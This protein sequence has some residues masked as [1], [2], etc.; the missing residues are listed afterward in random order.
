M[1]GQLARRRKDAA[2]A[3]ESA[4]QRELGFFALTASGVGIIIGAGIYVLIGAA[5]EKAGAPVWSAFLLAATLSALSGLGYCEL[6]TMFPR[7]AAE[8]EYSRHALPPWI[9]FLTGWLMISGLTVASAAVSLGFAEYLAHFFEFIPVKLGAVMLLAVVSAIALGGIRNSARLTIVMSLI[10]VGGLLFVIAV[11]A[12]HVGEVDVFSGGSTAGIAGAAA[13][14]F[15]AFIGFDEVTTLAEE[16]RNPGRNVP[17]ALIV[18]LVISTI[19]YMAVAVV[20]VSVLGPVALGQSSTPLADVVGQATGR[21]LDDVI[22]VIALIST[23]NTTLLATTAGSRVLY[24]MASVK[25]MPG[26]FGRVTRRHAPARAIMVCALISMAFA[27]AGDLTL[28]ASVTDFSVYMVFLSV[29]ATVII[30][31]F[32]RPDAPRPFRVPGTIGRLPI[33]PVLGLATTVAMLTR[34]DGTALL[35]GSATSVIGLAVGW[36]IV[37]RTDWVDRLAAEETSAGSV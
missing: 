32:K 23:L 15:F 3:P 11:G 1:S 35:I 19:L 9:A 36:L 6:G 12:G 21:R 25:A 29:N 4:L 18:A 33:I 16:T 24:G 26:L 37:R 14:V 20:A 10:Q 8:F 5:T 34:L 2:A 28:V 13:L 30:L 22:A 17:L 27:L 7:A 31:R